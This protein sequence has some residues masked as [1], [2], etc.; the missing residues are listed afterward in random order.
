MGAV[1]RMI[2]A[3]SGGV[4]FWGTASRP[5]ARRFRM[6]VNQR[7]EVRSSDETS[8]R[9]PLVVFPGALGDFVCLVPALEKI[10]ARSARR[11][12]LFCKG[13]LVPLARVTGIA[14][15]EPLEDRR[16]SWLFSA[17]PPAEADAFF[18][19]FGSIESFTGKGVPE[20]ER[21]VARWQGARGRVHPFRPIEPMHLARHFLRCLAPEDDWLEVPERTWLSLPEDVIG[22]HASTTAS[23][24]CPPL[25]VH[26]GSGGTAKRWSRAG[27]AEIA[28]RYV[29]RNRGVVILLGPAEEAEI[30]EWQQPGVRVVTGLDL[31]AVAAILV[32][33]GG[34]LGNDSG[35]SHLAGAVGARGVALFGPT[36]PR[37]WRP[38]SQR[39]LALRLTPWCGYEQRAPAAAVDAIERALAQQDVAFPLIAADGSDL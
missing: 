27:F 38:L 32:A 23:E 31:V 28:R 16:A 2:S 1:E 26:P 37:C 33:G 15:A 8:P 17:A 18:C 21:N 36:D 30:G 7:E 6:C 29:E 10:G 11:P 39:I 3:W 25:V 12:T 4:K 35:V 13:D 22:R 24:G 20:V 19:A 5:V 14:E 34:Y 9:G